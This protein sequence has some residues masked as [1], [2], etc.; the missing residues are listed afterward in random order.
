M[1]NYI[2]NHL[3]VIG[4]KENLN[5]FYEDV[6]GLGNA[7][8]DLKKVIPMLYEVKR[9]SNE[10]LIECYKKDY[11]NWGRKGFYG[12]TCEFDSSSNY[13][14]YKFY[15]TGIVPLNL[16]YLLIEKYPSLIFDICIWEPS[17][18]W[19]FIINGFYGHYTKHTYESFQYRE[20]SNDECL[21]FTFRFDYIRNVKSILEAIVFQ[22]TKPICPLKSRSTKEYNFISDHFSLLADV[23]GDIVSLNK[24]INYMKTND[25][26]EFKPEIEFHLKTMNYN[27][28]SAEVV[29]KIINECLFNYIINDIDKGSDLYAKTKCLVNK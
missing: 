16:F 21:F 5:R 13:L 29:E 25:F 3:T 1:G 24:I 11:K 26:K 4:D 23:D 8:F 27:D 22:G 14:Y 19:G 2:A 17:K 12:E 15:H 18:D 6:R 7:L 10:E 28:D 9:F 20:L